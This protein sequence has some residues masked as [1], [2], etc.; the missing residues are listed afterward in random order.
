MSEINSHY[1]GWGNIFETFIFHFALFFRQVRGTTISSEE[2]TSQRDVFAY[3]TDRALSLTLR[4]RDEETATML[5]SVD[6]RDSSAKS[7]FDR[8]RNMIGHSGGTA[9][10]FD[11]HK[12]AWLDTWNKGQVEVHGDLQLSKITW[13]AQYYLLSSLPPLF[14]DQ[15][16]PLDEVY[17]GIS[18]NSLGKGGE[19]GEYNGHIFWDNEMYIMP[20]VTL[21]H[22]DHAKAMLRFRAKYTNQARDYAGETGGKGYRY[23][24]EMAFSGQDVTPDKCVACKENALHVTA[25]VGWSIRQ[26]YSATRD[27]D[28]LTNSDYNACDMTKE[29]ARFWA[30]KCV[31]NTTKARYD[32]NG[33]KF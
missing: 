1:I 32:L 20:A 21:L 23:P 7:D 19:A 26:Y 28:F 3:F 5:M 9:R 17:Y 8:A 10:L 18:R 16:P 33:K 11:E 30:D 24:W 31:Y 4:D 29:I 2:G 13:F 25:A 27:A 6:T 14:A 15:K 22:P 12:K